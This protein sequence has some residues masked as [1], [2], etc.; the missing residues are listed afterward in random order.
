MN[1]LT[2]LIVDDD[3]DMRFYVRAC[4]RRLGPIIHRVLEAGDGLE[5]LPLVRSG[6]VQLVIADIV[7]PRLNGYGLCRAI[8]EDPGLGH[9]AVLLIS[10]ED[11]GPPPEVGANGFLAK[12]FNAGQLLAALRN[13]LSRPPLAGPE[14]QE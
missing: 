11:D 7:L 10:G 4:V 14:A 3:A 6:A 13:V 12:P 9:V 1:A 2:L 8:R 5:A